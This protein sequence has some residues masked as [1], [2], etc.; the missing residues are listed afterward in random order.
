MLLSLS[1]VIG[2]LFK[3]MFVRVFTEFLKK[4][5]KSICYRSPVSVFP[6]AEHVGVN[7]L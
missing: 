6:S 1:H 3:N 2:L 4:K 5:F 7:D